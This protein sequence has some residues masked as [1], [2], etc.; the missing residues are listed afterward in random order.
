MTF[1]ISDKLFDFSHQLHNFNF[2]LIIKLKKYFIIMTT[3]YLQDVAT[4]ISM[5]KV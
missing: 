2:L 4:Y 5:D 3:S 1:K